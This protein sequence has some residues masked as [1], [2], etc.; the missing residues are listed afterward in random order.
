MSNRQQRKN[1]PTEASGQTHAFVTPEGGSIDGH[2]QE[3]NV[4]AHLSAEQLKACRDAAKL[5]PLLAL[6]LALYLARKGGHE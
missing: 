2:G 1:P 3:V 4:L 6:Q 5:P